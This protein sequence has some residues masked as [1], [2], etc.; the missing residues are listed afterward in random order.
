MRTLAFIT[1]T[2]L[3]ILLFIAS[4]GML[5]VIEW[6]IL[7]FSMPDIT[8]RFPQVIGYEEYIWYTFYGIVIY[9][10]FILVFNVLIKQIRTTFKEMFR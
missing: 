6:Y 4:F 2:I 8:E 10:L 5:I 1:R 7:T 3:A 9:E